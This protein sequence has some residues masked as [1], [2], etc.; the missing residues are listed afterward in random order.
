MTSPAELLAG[1][2]KARDLLV[3]DTL[4]RSWCRDRF[5][6]VGII[7]EALVE[8]MRSDPE[9]VPGKETVPG[10]IGRFLGLQIIARPAIPSP[11]CLPSLGFR[12]LADFP[13][14]PNPEREL[15]RSVTRSLG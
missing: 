2:Q 15:C 4:P 9:F 5:V 6:G 7:P 12:A 14:P 3:T 8:A 11:V 13:I 1:I 10:E